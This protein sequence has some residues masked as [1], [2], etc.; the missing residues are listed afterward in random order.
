MRYFRPP[1][2]PYCRNRPLMSRKGFYKRGEREPLYGLVPITDDGEIIDGERP[3]PLRVFE[4]KFCGVV[5]LFQ[6]REGDLE[7]GGQAKESW[8]KAR[9]SQTEQIRREQQRLR[10]QAEATS[11]QHEHI[12]REQLRLQQ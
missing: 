9:A 3:T 1:N 10:Q 5:A 2:C 8:D 7:S 6:D 12:V 11:A 4:C